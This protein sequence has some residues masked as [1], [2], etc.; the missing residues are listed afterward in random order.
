MKIRAAMEKTRHFI[1]LKTLFT[2]EDSPDYEATGISPDPDDMDE[3][4]MLWD[5]EAIKGVNPATDPRDSKLSTTRGGFMV[6]ES[7]Q[8]IK[9]K[10]KNLPQVKI[11]D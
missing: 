4:L 7:Y 9:S 5:V 10:L 2:P 6:R 11:W 8:N 3:G 1:E